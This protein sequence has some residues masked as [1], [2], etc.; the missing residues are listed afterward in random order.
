MPHATQEVDASL[1][2][3][4]GRGEI[5][6]PWK[7]VLRI[8]SLTCHS[9]AAG[10]TNPDQISL[11]VRNQLVWGPSSMNAGNQANLTTVVETSSLDRKVL[12]E[13]SDQ[14]KSLGSAYASAPGGGQIQIINGNA[15][16]TLTYQTELILN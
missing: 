7:N 11:Y 13:L 3:N 10:G 15:T 6:V 4:G 12:V 5:G 14:S 16:Y 2:K 1:S 9:T 8:T